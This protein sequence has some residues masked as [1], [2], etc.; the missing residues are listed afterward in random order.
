MFYKSKKSFTSAVL[1][2]LCWEFG[3]VGLL[4]SVVVLSNVCV[5]N[6][7]VSVFDWVLLSLFTRAQSIII[8]RI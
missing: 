6:S 2:V 7:L 3:I 8:E 4:L 1:I 5:S